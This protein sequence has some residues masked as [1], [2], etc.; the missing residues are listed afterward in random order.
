MSLSPGE[1]RTARFVRRSD[2]MA[3]DD[4]DTRRAAERGTFA[5][6]TGG[7]SAATLEARFRGMGGTSVPAP[8][9]MR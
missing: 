7:S 1:T 8:R 4:L 5:M 3:L 9:R 6:W 2:G